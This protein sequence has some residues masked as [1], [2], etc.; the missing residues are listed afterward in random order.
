MQPYREDIYN[1]YDEMYR[2]G[3]MVPY[4]FWWWFLPRPPMPP[5][6][7]FPPGPRPPMPGPRP[8]MPGPRPPYPPRPRNED[9]IG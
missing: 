3:Y 5:R 7:P 6:P 8:P 9:S 1:D 4:W 2:Q